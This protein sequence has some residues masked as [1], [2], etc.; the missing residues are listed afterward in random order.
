MET[1]ANYVVVGA[2]AIA[3]V[4]G[5]LGFLL[6]FANVELDRQFAYYDIDFRSVSGLGLASDVTFA[7]FPV[8]QVVDIGLSPE[9]N[10]RIRVRIEIDAATPV[11]ADSIATIEA[12][13]VTGVSFVELS[14]G[15]PEA[16]LLS[17]VSAQEVP[18]IRAGQSALQSL[19]QD[20]PEILAETL[21]LVRDLREVLDPESRETIRSILHNLDEGAASLNRAL[22][23]V[24][25]VGGVASSFASGLNQLNETM[26]TLG[27]DLRVVLQET[28]RTVTS[29]GDLTQELRALVANGAETLERVDGYIDGQLVPATERIGRAGAAVEGALVALSESAS[30]GLGRLAAEAQALLNN[31][32]TLVEQIRRDPGRFFLDSRAPE[33]RR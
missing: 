18:R 32:G 8:G 1:K 11:R 12:L 29:A 20:A 7:G 16:P 24:E 25:D 6:W 27:E 19:S 30:P 26:S 10:G 31:I 28:E 22:A 17:E 33:Y 2:F 15:S 21:Q 4:L 5:L 14:T 3:G 9:G 23:Q 13:G